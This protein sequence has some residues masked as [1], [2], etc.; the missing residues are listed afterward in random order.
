VNA[1]SESLHAVAPTGSHVTFDGDPPCFS[2][3]PDDSSRNVT[4]KNAERS[5][6]AGPSHLP[7]EPPAT[8]RSDD[9]EAALARALDR[10]SE[11]GR[12]DVV[13]LLA[14]ELQARRL[15][16]AGVPATPLGDPKRGRVLPER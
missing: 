8:T 4:E 7:A 9:A 5:D 3:S 16:R 6:L 15:D 2:V 13:A 12:F 14:G 1:Q 11:A 10:A